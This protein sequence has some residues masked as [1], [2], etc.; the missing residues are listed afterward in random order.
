MAKAS[1]SASAEAPTRPH[2]I[3]LDNRRTLNMTGVNEVSAF[4]EKQLILNTE[5]GRM[6]VD[7]E[8]LHVTAL[9]LEEGRIAIDGQI[10]AITYTG[11]GKVVRKG[12]SGFF[13]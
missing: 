10:N 11:R 6:T 9:L 13:R 12:L 5:G 1:A 2:S 7:G 8:G 4:D 3:T